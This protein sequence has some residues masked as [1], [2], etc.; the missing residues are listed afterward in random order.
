MHEC[1]DGVFLQQRAR[2]TKTAYERSTQLI[3]TIFC[4][5]RAVSTPLSVPATELPIVSSEM[6]SFVETTAHRLRNSPGTP[7]N[8]PKVLSDS[9]P[10]L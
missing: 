4:V 6:Y 2:H 3:E 9:F 10:L 5:A 1:Q 7:T 8:Q